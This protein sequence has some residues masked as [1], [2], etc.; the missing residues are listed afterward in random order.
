[1][2]IV[3]TTHEENNVG[4]IS[5]R[6]FE[7]VEQ[8]SFISRRTEYKDHLGAR[9]CLVERFFT[10][11]SMTMLLAVITVD[12]FENYTAYAEWLIEMETQFEVGKNENN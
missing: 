3:K 1:M 5:R 11:K 9:Y 6:R 12:Y 7:I 2:I 4:V 10:A 8:E